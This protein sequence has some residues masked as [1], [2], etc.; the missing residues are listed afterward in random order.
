MR[1]GLWARDRASEHSGEDQEGVDHPLLTG[2]EDAHEDR[3][4]A[5]AGGGSIPSPNLAVHHCR[6]DGV[7]GRPVGCFHV[8][9][10]DEEEKRVPV[11]PQV[12]GQ[13][14]IGT[15]REVPLQQ[16]V[17]TPAQEAPGDSRPMPTDL[18]ADIAITEVS[19]G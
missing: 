1:E 9:A 11:A 19:S 13:A 15:A 16:G 6:T 3:L 14:S 5:C 17:Q 8:L 7:F 18:P 12:C 4:G 10:V 2:S